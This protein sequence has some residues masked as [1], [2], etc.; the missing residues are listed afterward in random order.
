MATQDDDE[1]P[2]KALG[3]AARDFSGLLSPFNFFRRFSLAH[4]FISTYS[5]IIISNKS[6]FNF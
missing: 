2:K 4:L 1:H 5:F 6:R 3:W